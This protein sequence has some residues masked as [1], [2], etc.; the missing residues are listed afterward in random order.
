MKLPDG[1]LK[2]HV[3][4]LGK[5]GS[6]KSYCAKGIVERLAR[7]GHQVCVL[8]PTAAWWGLRLGAD[9]KSKGLHFVLIGGKHGD[10][11]LAAQSG[12][13]V[14]RLVTQQHAS[15][16]CDLSGMTV[17]EYTRWFIDFASV[18]YTTIRQPL[19]LVI[20]EAH[21]FMPQGG[22]AMD[23]ERG[24]MLHAGN[25]LMSGGRSLGIRGMMITQRPAKLHK[26]ALTCADTLI[27]MRV[28]APQDRSAIKDWVD[29]AGDP[30][31]GKAVL[32]SLAGL[33]RGEGWA[34]YPEG[35]YLER[36][37]FPKIKTYDSSATPEHGA[38]KSPEVSQ[39]DLEEVRKAMADAVA[40]AKANDPRELR[41]QVADLRA[42][43]AKLEK[44]TPATKVE[45]KTVEKL[46][47]KP[48]DLKR[49]EGLAERL[50]K[51]AETIR[52]AGET[53]R[54]AVETIAAAIKPA[55]APVVHPPA[56]LPE[57]FRTSN[58]TPVVHVQPRRLNLPK[59]PSERHT[60][61]NGDLSPME[62]RLL[63]VLAQRPNEAINKARVL[64]LA[65][66]ASSGPTSKAFAKFIAH[67]LAIGDRGS[68]QV[69]TDGINT[70]GDFEP[71][72]SGEALRS[73]ILGRCSGMEQALLGVL[74]SE[75]PRAVSKS[76]ILQRSNYASS[77]PTSKA[78]AKF[79]R[80]GWAT[81]S[82]GELRASDELF[83]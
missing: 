19:H 5:T 55:M 6:G 24:K 71:L 81:G 76:E 67:G 45:T 65:D 21:Y 32:D 51:V 16:V 69:T 38:K 12:A 42:E 52:A 10:I 79:V 61:E 62:R 25:R 41:K 57:A 37:T 34:W 68:L 53:T 54:A 40:E 8:D 1:I 2:Q 82:R 58:T 74:F 66:Y 44:A 36:L 63:T 48:A 46:V 9:G 56:K 17:G 59:P 4:I 73:Q 22:G 31:Q 28:I 30:A 20:D 70:L 47:I 23:V 60:G 49:I 75:Y 29:G 39:I 35:G 27:A 13:A 64:V 83:E 15:V 26:D 50:A 78:F 18:L 72:P 77:G 11:P 80:A 33:K 3:A 7:D 14:A 43:I